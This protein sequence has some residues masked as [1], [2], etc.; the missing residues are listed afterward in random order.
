MRLPARS[1]RSPSRSE[2]PLNK[3]A[4]SSNAIRANKR[5]AASK[6]NAAVKGRG[7]VHGPLPLLTM[8]VVDPPRGAGSL[9]LVRASS[10]VNFGMGFCY[11]LPASCSH[12]GSGQ[13]VCESI[14]RHASEGRDMIAYL[15]ERERTILPGKDRGEMRP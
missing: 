14:R 11:L 2:H 7:R 13:C 3:T 5:K 8:S 12:N 15:A 9:T 1:A 4:K 6:R 10:R